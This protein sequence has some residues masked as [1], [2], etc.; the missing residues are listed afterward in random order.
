MDQLQELIQYV[1]DNPR[2]SAL[3]ALALVLVYVLL[4]YRPRLTR[5]A[6]ARFNQLREERGDVYRAFRP[7][8]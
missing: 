7:P 6:D 1:Q 3:F 2:N 4:N 5:E 8:H